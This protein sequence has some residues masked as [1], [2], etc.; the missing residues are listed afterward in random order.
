MII[1]STGLVTWTLMRSIEVRNI[2]WSHLNT[3][4]TPLPLDIS[5]DW[6]PPSTGFVYVCSDWDAGQ[7]VYSAT[8]VSFFQ[9]L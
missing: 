5:L 4:H 9:Q 7:F 3:D 6:S 8:M 2:G 1:K